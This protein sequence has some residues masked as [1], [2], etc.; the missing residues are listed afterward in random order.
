MRDP[1]EWGTGE[2]DQFVSIVIP[3]W[4]RADVLRGALKSLVSQDYPGNKYEIVVS[5]DG[6][7][8]TTPAVVGEYVSSC[9]SPRVNAVRRRH[10]GANAARN[11]GIQEAQGELI[12][13][14]DDD[15][16]APTGWLQM[17]VQGARRH[18]SAS[19]LG[20]PIRLRLEGRQ[21]RFCGN[22]GFGE[23]ELDLGPED[24]VGPLLWSANMAIRRSAFDTVGL[25]REDIPRHGEEEEWERR[26]FGAGGTT[27]YIADAWVW[28][29]RTEAQL[30][31]G[32]LLKTSFI[33]GRQAAE[34][35]RFE[36]RPL[37][38]P[39]ELAGIPRVL[40]HAALHRCEWGILNASRRLGMVWEHCTA[41]RRR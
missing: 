39:S 35:L 6:S 12:C 10:A 32:S 33:R 2:T 34:R 40:G 25:F 20:G 27:A 26:L 4:N 22:E 15:V 23:A 1:I 36:G 18:P 13:L 3:T 19:C 5:D 14:V 16:E 28:H 7:I 41:T 30:R 9:S 31:V 38:V 11:A 21:P 17:I 29:R 8:D 24:V 37:S